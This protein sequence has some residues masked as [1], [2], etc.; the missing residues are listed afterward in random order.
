[1]AASMAPVLI[2]RPSNGTANIG[3]AFAPDAPPAVFRTNG[4]C[5]GSAENSPLHKHQPIVNF[6]RAGIIT[7]QVP[8]PLGGK[9]KIRRTKGRGANSAVTEISPCRP[10]GHLNPGAVCNPRFPKAG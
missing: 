10:S 4:N 2:R 8:S 9:K 7:R 3:A 5:P 1:M 6:Q